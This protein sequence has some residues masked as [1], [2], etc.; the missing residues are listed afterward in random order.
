MKGFFIAIFLSLFLTMPAL[1]TDW[2]YATESMTGDMIVYIDRDSIE[3]NGNIARFTTKWLYKDPASLYRKRGI[4][5][6]IIIY[7]INCR[8]RTYLIEH[9]W[10]YNSKGKVQVGYDASYAGFQPI[11][12]DSLIDGV[13]DYMCR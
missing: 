2:N 1:A 6:S 5:H 9:A 11:P 12:S 4:S 3:Y 8:N 7:R 10:E 13:Y